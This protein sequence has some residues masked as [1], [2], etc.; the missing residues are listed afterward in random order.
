MIDVRCIRK[1]GI[2][3]KR[4]SSVPVQENIKCPS[5]L[6]ALF[7]PLQRYINNRF[8]KNNTDCVSIAASVENCTDPCAGEDDSTYNSFFEVGTLL[9]VR[10]G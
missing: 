10:W 3:V 1:N 6:H 8:N 5:D 9:R 7:E 2:N 4:R